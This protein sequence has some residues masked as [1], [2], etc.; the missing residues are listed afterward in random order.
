[1][2][3]ATIPSDDDTTMAIVSRIAEAE[4][5]AV[6]DLPPVYDVLDPE[7]LTSLLD[8]DGVTVSFT[9]CGYRVTVTSDDEISLRGTDDSEVD[10]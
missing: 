2:A 9:Y 8:S 10:A 7:C 6:T 4:N 1:M 3:L 5:T